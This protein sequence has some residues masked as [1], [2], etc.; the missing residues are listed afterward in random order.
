MTPTAVPTGSPTVAI[1]T[2][3]PTGAPTKTDWAAKVDR[4]AKKDPNGAFDA[5]F[6][7]TKHPTLTP[8]PRPTNPPTTKRWFNRDV[9]PLDA[10]AAADEADASNDRWKAKAALEADET[11]KAIVQGDDDWR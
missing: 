3:S 11:T 6:A 4:L 9:D 10:N 2:A 8:T 1:P 7:S 5:L